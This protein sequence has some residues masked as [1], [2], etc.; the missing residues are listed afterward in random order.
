M[1]VLVPV[2][3]GE[4]GD[5]ARLTAAE[6][7]FESAELLRLVGWGS[8]LTTSPCSALPP[9][10]SPTL[11]IFLLAPASL[12]SFDIAQLLFRHEDGLPAG[13][14]TVSPSDGLTSNA[15]P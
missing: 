6:N 7:A 9:S 5:V 14:A 10:P 11:A 3:E 4:N 8:G 2:V 13:T 1:L 12:L 15:R